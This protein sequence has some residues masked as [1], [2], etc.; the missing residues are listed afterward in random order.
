MFKVSILVVFVALVLPLS[1]TTQISAESCKKQLSNQSFRSKEELLQL[2]FCGFRNGELQNKSISSK[3]IAKLHSQIKTL[4]PLAACTS[5]VMNDSVVTLKFRNQA[6]AVVPGT[7]GQATM[8]ISPMLKLRCQ[9]DK[10]DST[11]MGFV[12][13]DGSIEVRFSPIAGLL[14]FRSISGTSLTYYCRNS[15]KTSAMVME[16]KKPIEKQKIAI[17]GKKDR[18]VLDIQTEN[19]R[20]KEDIIV[21]PNRI[22]MPPFKASFATKG[23]SVSVNNSP[24][25]YAP[26]ET[27]DLCQLNKTLQTAFQTGD[28]SLVSLVEVKTAVYELEKKDISLSFGVLK[29]D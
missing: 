29:G 17:S 10:V 7:W 23:D 3:E 5:V 1:A 2:F 18:L 12:V 25:K 26:N 15:T 4:I 24:W 8:H 28:K 27:K 11:K 6:K 9:F 14:G 22:D 21:A 16:Q 20:N 13:Q 19:F